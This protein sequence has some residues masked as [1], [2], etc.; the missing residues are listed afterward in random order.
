M[1]IAPGGGWF[2]F[3][4]GGATQLTCITST[5]TTTVNMVGGS[6][7]P[8]GAGGGGGSG[9]S[10]GAA[11]GGGGYNGGHAEAWNGNTFNDYAT[12]G[13]SYVAFGAT[14]TNVLNNNTGDGAVTLTL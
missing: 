13:G 2:S 4:T 10:G 9:R 3:T 12:G 8:T 7:L 11:G 1:Y 6:G 5:S 14:Q